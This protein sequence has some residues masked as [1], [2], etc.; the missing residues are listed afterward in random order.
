MQVKKINPSITLEP[1]SV[2][3]SKNKDFNI[4]ALRGFAALI[5]AIAHAVYFHYVLAPGYSVKIGPD[6]VTGHYCVLIFFMLSGYVIG[7]SNKTPLSGTMAI[8]TYLK[9]RLVRLYPIYIICLLLSF[10]TATSF[11]DLKTVLSHLTFTQILFSELI[12]ENG[13]LWSLHYEVLYYLLFIPISFLKLNPL[14][15]A[16][17]SILLG[18]GNF[19]IYPQVNVPIIT[20][21]FFGFS[22][23]VSGLI[24]SKYF[25]KSNS[26]VNPALLL[27]NIFL[28]LCIGPFNILATILK[29]IIALV[30]ITLEFPS[31]VNLAERIITFTD[32]AYLPYCFM[33]LL[34]ACGKDFKYR[35]WVFVLLQ[36]LPALTFNYILRNLDTPGIENFILPSVFYII[37]LLIFFIRTEKLKLISQPFIKFGIWLGSISYALYVVHFPIIYLFNK[38]EVF[39]G[40]TTFFL[41]RLLLFLTLTIIFSYLLEKKFQPWIKSK[42]G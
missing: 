32:F 2:K 22:F 28:I 19:L 5:V 7:I 4:E 31:S 14:V 9:K 8:L 29:K 20:S 42:I 6:F 12:K 35:K 18:L 16:I 38:I 30:N 21:Y 11:Y 36:V 13:P 1:N 34:I 33:F 25:L 40:T 17:L 39:S 37:S 41:F 26:K 23:W 15:L 27:S 10:L 3:G 24:I